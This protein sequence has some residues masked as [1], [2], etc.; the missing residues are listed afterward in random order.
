MSTIATPHALTSVELL[1]KL[2]AFD[3]VTSKSNLPLIAFVADYLTGHGIPFIIAP[4]ETGDKAALFATIGPQIDGGVV[5]S[6]HTDVVPVTGQNWTT[7]PFTLRRDGTR[8]YGRGACDM[9]GFDAVCLA[10]A[11]ELMMMPLKAPVHILLSYDEETTC[12]GVMDVI[13]RMGVDLPQPRAVIVGEPTSMQVADA[14]K[15]VGSFFTTVHGFE[16]HSSMPRAGVNAISGAAEIVNELNIIF[17]E[18]VT[19][20][21]PTGRFD[22]P[23]TSVHVG[24]INGGTA[25]NITAKECRINWEFRGV[26]GQDD[27]EIP[28]RIERFAQEVIIPKLA[29]FGGKASVTTEREV[30]VPGLSPEPGSAAETL[31]KRLTNSNNVIT[32][33]YGS[34]AGRF[35]KA[36]I[37]TVLCGPGDIAQA[38]QPDE[39][40]EESEII[41][42]EAFVR[43]L[44]LELSA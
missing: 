37:P 38:H 35:Q 25:R 16:V 32:V 43:R 33:P 28:L 2:V 14:H 20:G 41:A 24:T 3:T 44:G 23:Y 19:R 27:D 34:E 8:L 11:P 21:D 42:C 10:M 22:P 18:M 13:A 30:L 12:L 7:D 1:E 5:L 26:P 36:G 15:S 6:G 40:I 17:D 31:A 4:N 29:R 39:Y 9:K